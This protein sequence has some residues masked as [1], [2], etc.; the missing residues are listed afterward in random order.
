MPAL[1]GQASSSAADLPSPAAAPLL[2]VE[3]DHNSRE[4]QVF[5]FSDLTLDLPD[6]C[7]ASIF[8]K[9]SAKDRNTCSLVCKRWHFVEA[10]SRDRLTL[11]AHAQLDVDAVCLMTRFEHISCLSLKCVRKESSIDDKTLVLIGKHCTRLTRLKLKGCKAIT[12]DGLEH[13]SKFCGS[14]EKFSCGSCGFGARGLNFVLY[15][16]PKLEDL[17]VKRLKKL[18][19]YP[20]AILAGKSKLQRL[21]LKEIL[22]AHLF[23]TLIAGSKHLRT[24]IFARNPGFWDQFFE[25][26]TEYLPELVELHVESLKMGDTA[27]RAISRCSKLEVLYVTKVSDCSDNGYSAIANGCRNLRKLHIDDRKTSRI[28]DE[29]LLAIG[30]QCTHLQELVLIGVKVTARSLVLIAS[31]CT[32]LE[33][34]ALC[35]S[36]AVGDRELSCIADRCMSLK[37]LCIK[38]CPISDLG[39]EGFAS[40][41]PSLSKV[42][43]KKC[44]DVTL[45]SAT[46]LQ[47]N[48]ASLVVSLDSSPLAPEDDEQDETP[49]P[50]GGEARIIRAPTALLCNRLPLIKKR[51]A[52]AASSFL[53]RFPKPS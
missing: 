3:K 17:S 35:N 19:E 26:I 31:N 14:L 18:H 10:K 39:L 52:F 43:V 1:M 9:L 6:E 7:L 41:C 47:M 33:R 23:G 42:K 15:N 51:L 36:D 20:E 50:Q 28:G 4:M 44:K 27:L 22:S 21:C 13:F 25:L 12:D 45:A 24:L 38:N 34:M 32:G 5:V 2:L 11:R 29:G 48:R 37:K 46:W 40:G 49:H 8:Q 16:C 53:R 30:K